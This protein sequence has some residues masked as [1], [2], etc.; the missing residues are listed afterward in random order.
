MKLIMENWRAFQLAEATTAWDPKEDPQD[1]MDLLKALST[2]SDQQ[3]V[4]KVLQQLLADKEIAKVLEALSEMFQEITGE[5]EVEV[6]I[7]EGLADLPGDVGRS[8]AGIGL[9]LTAKVEEFLNSTPGGHALGTVAAPL[10][11]LALGALMIQGG[12]VS[13]G[14]L[15]TIGKLVSGAVTP[16]SLGDVVADLGTEALEALQE[17]KKN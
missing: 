13:A 12:D 1:T 14:G 5:E 3:K 7:D 17:R 10:L 15:K 11:G 8:V 2:E 4:Q 16:E 6:D 9:D